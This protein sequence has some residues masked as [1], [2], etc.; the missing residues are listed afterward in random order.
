M[1]F[2]VL[3]IIFQLEIGKKLQLKKLKKLEK[4]K[5][6]QFLSVEQDFILRL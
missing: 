5:K 1:D 3:K 2:I 4:E 6:T